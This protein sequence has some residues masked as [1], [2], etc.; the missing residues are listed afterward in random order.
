[1]RE[2]A[3]S[4]AEAA[5]VLGLSASAISQLLGGKNRPGLATAQRIAAARGV[6]WAAMLAGEV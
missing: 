1:M 2:H 6:E 3:W 4:Q 5:R